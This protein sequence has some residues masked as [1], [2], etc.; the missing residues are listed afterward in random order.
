M[1]LTVRGSFGSYIIR[2]RMAIVLLSGGLDS[3]VALAMTPRARLCLN[4]DYG[5]RAARAERRVASMLARRAGVSFL[6]LRLPWLRGGALTDRGRA[7][8]RGP[9]K[10]SAAAVWVPNRNGVFI[11]VAAAIAEARGWREIVT[12][13]NREEAATFPDN[14]RAFIR[15]INASLRFSTA[16]GVRV[17]APTAAWDKRRIMRE[18]RRRGVPID[19]LWPCYRGGRRICGRCES[20]VR[21]ERAR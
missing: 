2:A 1:P 17:V 10:T 9:S 11:N 7:L 18:A 21:F 20:C 13:F 15:A 19:A 8:P 14:S 16:N 5:Q 3:A 6:H 4:F 12:G